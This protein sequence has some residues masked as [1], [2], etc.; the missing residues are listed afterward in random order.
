MGKNANE[1]PGVALEKHYHGM[2]DKTLMR[3]FILPTLVLL[4]AINVFPLI[5]SLFLSF[6]DYSAKVANV[7][8]KNPAWIG[9][10][11]FAD[12]LADP[13]M[14]EKF[15][16]TAK[17]VIMT[18]AGEM[19]LGFGLALLLQL[20]FKGRGLITTLLVLPMTMSPVIVGLMWKL[21]YDPNWGMFN[22]LLGLGRVDWI[23]DPARNL[24]SIVIADI[25]MWTP[26][27]M[28]LSLAGLGAVPKYLYEAAEIDRASWWFKFTRITLPMVSPIL[29]LAL[30]FR[31]IEAFKIFDLPMGITGRGAMAPPLLAMHLYNVSFVTWNTSYG[32]AIGYIMLI[33][34]L[35]ITLV[36]VKYL[37]RAKQ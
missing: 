25:W 5:W 37:N 35:A 17:Y 24:Y 18:V 4:I 6:T 30:I 16:T 31:I 32:S 28:L 14:W 13:E 27:V 12:I 26:F 7:W 3:V 36:L 21:F 10:G 11:N 2:R 8:G 19:I 22:F 29:M 34:V 23:Q 20:D 15:I 9:S 1:T 33:M